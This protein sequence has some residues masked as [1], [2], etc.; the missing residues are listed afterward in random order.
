[1]AQVCHVTTEGERE[2]VVQRVLPYIYPV[3]H[4]LLV[5]AKNTHFFTYSL[6]LEIHTT[7]CMYDTRRF[8]TQDEAFCLGQQK[9]TPR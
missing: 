6:T 8:M 9:A 2:C 4:I 3:R 5:T 7:S 1:M